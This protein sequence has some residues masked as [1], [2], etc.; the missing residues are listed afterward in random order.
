MNG[1]SLYCI[2]SENIKIKGELMREFRRST[3]N[4]II[5]HTLIYMFI[6]TCFSY[7]SKQTIYDMLS[8]RL[9]YDNI[10]I[11]NNAQGIDWKQKQYQGNYRVF[12]EID[13][14]CRAVVFDMSN[15]EP[16]MIWGYYPKS[17]DTDS[18]AVVG[19]NINEGQVIEESGK[20]WITLLDQKFEVVGVVGANYITSCDDLIILF[21]LELNQQNLKRKTIVID[22]EYPQYLDIIKEDIVQKNPEVEFIK[23]DYKGTARLTKNSYFFKLLNIE[24]I[25]LVVFTL[26]LLG[27]YQ[28]G[29]YHNIR[30]VYEMLGIPIVRVI[31]YEE[32]ES[33]A[34]NVISFIISVILGFWLKIAERSD[35][36]NIVQFGS[37][38]TFF[39]CALI[40]FFL[41]V[42]YC[43]VKKWFMVQKFKVREEL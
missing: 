30:R 43:H 31:I 19:K 24:M 35:L 14:C 37:I 16:P 42:D 11:V 18:K 3:I 15:W 39:S 25:L 23:G 1:N 40:L 26:V 29:R 2:F 34:V 6:I 32:F 22:A 10:V 20:K 5:I 7:Y 12:A 33:I 28:Y 8:N 13:E 27:K 4:M 36:V 41:V 9:Y 38:I 21:G 17:I